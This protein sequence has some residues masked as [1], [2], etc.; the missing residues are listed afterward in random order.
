MLF[1]LVIEFYIL[2][3]QILGKSN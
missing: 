3:V 1:L 2:T